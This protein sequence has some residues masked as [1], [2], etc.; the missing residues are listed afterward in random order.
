MGVIVKLQSVLVGSLFSFFAI[1]GL[2]SL[3]AQPSIGVDKVS[4]SF[5]AQQGGP[6]VTQPLNVTGSSNGLA[7]NVTSN[8]SWLKVSPQSGNTPSALT[9][10]ADPAGLAAGTVTGALTFFSFNTFQVQVTLTVGP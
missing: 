5:T 8:A 9:V 10:T 6:P 1:G 2:S 3:D 4:L 7:F